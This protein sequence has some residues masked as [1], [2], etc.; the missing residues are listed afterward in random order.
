MFLG[1]HQTGET[2]DPLG[3]GSGVDTDFIRMDQGSFK[4]NGV[5]EYDPFSPIKVTAQEWLPNPHP[6]RVGRRL[7]GQTRLQ[8][9][10]QKIE[11]TRFIEET[12]IS[13]PLHV[14]IRRP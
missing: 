2:A 6:L 13:K 14:A 10:M 5:T 7:G 1:Q 11:V 4:L 3:E 9:G 12:Q 8:P